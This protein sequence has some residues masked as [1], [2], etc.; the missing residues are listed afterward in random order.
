MK[1]VILLGN[2]TKS[3]LLFNEKFQSVKMSFKIKYF[4]LCKPEMKIYFMKT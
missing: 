3:K 1:S 2:G 4:V